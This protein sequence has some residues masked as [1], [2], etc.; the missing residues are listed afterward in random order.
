MQGF[1][2]K[3]S[4]ENAEALLEMLKRPLKDEWLSK[5]EK[6]YVRVQG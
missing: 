3:M 4:S 2:E 5:I 6:H 1:W